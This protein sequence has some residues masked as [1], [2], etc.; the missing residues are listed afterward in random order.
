MPI[1]VPEEEGT[2][3]GAQIAGSPA[4]DM[5]H[6]VAEQ[7]DGII[8]RDRVHASPTFPLDHVPVPPLAR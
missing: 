1:A 4:V 2:F 8:G 3:L 7:Q 5:G 6:T